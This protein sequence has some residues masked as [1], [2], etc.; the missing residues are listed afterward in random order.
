MNLEQNL[1]SKAKMYLI[2]QPCQKNTKTKE[3]LRF[4]VWLQDSSLS[5]S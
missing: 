2:C 3:P 4:E 5:F 1:E